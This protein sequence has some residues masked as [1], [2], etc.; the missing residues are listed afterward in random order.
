MLLTCPHCGKKFDR[1]YKLE[2]CKNECLD[3]FD[4]GLTL[5]TWGSKLCEGPYIENTLAIG[6]LQK[7]SND[8]NKLIEDLTSSKKIMSSVINEQII[9]NNY[10]VFNVL[11][12]GASHN[13]ENKN[14]IVY[15]KVKDFSI[16]EI[17]DLQS[18]NQYSWLQHD[19]SMGH[20]Y[21]DDIL[22]RSIKQICKIKNINNNIIGL[23]LWHETSF[24]GAGNTEHVFINKFLI[25]V[26]K[27]Y[28]NKGN[29]TLSFYNN[30]YE[31]IINEL[32]SAGLELKTKLKPIVP[33]FPFHGILS[34]TAIISPGLYL[35]SQKLKRFLIEKNIVDTVGWEFQV[36]KTD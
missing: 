13:E 31:Y 9:E 26:K 12:F 6:T 10:L 2:D 29:N 19:F 20:S 35:K 3:I 21:D 25:S 14:E 36:F 15:K 32:N 22:I 18:N 5:E 30:N 28:F 16:E 7:S 8:F 17:K 23:H 1:L 33:S 34:L 24:S 11:N 27:V 4:F